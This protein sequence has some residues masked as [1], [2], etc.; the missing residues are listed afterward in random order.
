M[1][2]KRATIK[3]VAAQAGVSIAVVSYVL[4]D[5]PNQTIPASTKQRVF[6]AVTALDYT[7]N[8]TARRLRKQVGL[9]FGLVSFWGIVDPSFTRI[10]DGIS[11]TAQENDLS[12]LFLKSDIDVTNAKYINA[13][14]NGQIDGII[15]LSPHESNSEFIEQK[16]LELIVQ[17]KLPAVIINGS[18]NMEGVSYINLDYY[19]STYQCV[20]YLHAHG[21]KKIA[22]LLPDSSEA[23]DK[24][25]IKRNLGF[26]DAMASVHLPVREGYLFHSDQIESVIQSILNGN[27]PTAIVCNKSSYACEF[28][29]T[30]LEMGYNTAD[31]V[32]IIAANSEPS[33][34]F[35]FP[36]L[37]ALE[38]PLEDVGQNA[39]QL[40]LDNY[41]KRKTPAT[42]LFPNTLFLGQTVK[43]LL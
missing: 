39:A 42:L 16:H 26:L 41:E 38:I 32:S 12:I 5:V 11:K 37:T 30:V 25:A 3:D 14:K 35:L 15:V 21:H 7:P 1:K 4:N 17:N 28:M 2:E 9:T 13:Y 6:D 29:K 31:L 18:T 27:G 10:L 40:L 34:K 36:N 19:H 24:N 22:Y 23:N 33:D 20:A 8:H 43:E